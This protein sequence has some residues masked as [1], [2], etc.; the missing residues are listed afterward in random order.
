MAE[1]KKPKRIKIEHIKREPVK[2]PVK[3]YNLTEEDMRQIEKLLRDE[4]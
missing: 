4:K 1:M 3:I 2:I